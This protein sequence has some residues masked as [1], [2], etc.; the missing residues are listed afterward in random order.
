MTS[1]DELTTLILDKINKE[2][3]S[4]ISIDGRCAAGKT[5]LANNISSKCDSNIIHMDDFF[6]KPNQRL[7]SIY[8]DNNINV[9][10]KRFI[11]EILIPLGNKETFSYRSWDCKK[12]EYK[13]SILVNPNKLTIVEGSYSCHP[14]LGEYYDLSVFLDIDNDKQIDRL[15]ARGSD[16]E[17]FKNKWIPLEEEYFNKL[18][19]ASK[20]HLYYLV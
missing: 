11:D 4:V 20:C 16:V 3:I 14:L 1:L 6:L 18:N 17:M 12:E 7:D 13:D 8:K 9:E 5:T 15:R 2:N 19:I 10:Y